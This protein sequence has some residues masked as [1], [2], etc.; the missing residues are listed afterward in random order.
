MNPAKLHRS[1]AVALLVLAFAV[2]AWAKNRAVG[3]RTPP[4]AF[5]VPLI[6]GTVVDDVTGA[7]VV[8]AELNAG[9]RFDATDTQGRFD[10]K[11]VN[12]FGQIVVTAS[13][14][15]YQPTQVTVVPGGQTTFTIRMKPTATTTIRLTNGQTKQYDTESIKF[16]YPLFTGYIESETE[17]FC[18]V[19]DSTKVSYSR[20]QMAKLA[21][22]AQIVPAGACCTGNAAKMTLTLKSGEVM[23]VLFTDTCQERYV[24]DVDAREHVSGQFVHIL[25]T[26]IAEIIFP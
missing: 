19:T 5:S 26:D 22:P 8:G 18:K 1:L 21:G 2:P 7:P 9:T 3:H 25:I 11:S 15:G 10:L 24:V 23:D 16:G 14:S 4:G 17:D 12:G 13:R 20:S 6:N